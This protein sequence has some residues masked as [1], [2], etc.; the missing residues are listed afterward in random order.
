MRVNRFVLNPTA[1]VRLDAADLNGLVLEPGAAAIH[2]QLTIVQFAAL[3]RTVDAI[4]ILGMNPH[5]VHWPLEKGSHRPM[6]IGY[7]P[8]GNRTFPRIY[9][10]SLHNLML[11]DIRD[12]VSEGEPS[13]ISNRAS[14]EVCLD[15]GHAIT[16]EAHDFGS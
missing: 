5:H 4:R 3:Y 1:G 16:E 6:L 14:F 7:W 8:D 11:P 9:S 15:Y 10:I 13:I 12:V 2:L